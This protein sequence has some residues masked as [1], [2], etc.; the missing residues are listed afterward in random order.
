MAYQIKVKSRL[1]AL[2]RGQLETLLFF[3]ARQHRKREEI[4][5]T[6]ARYGLPELVDDR[7][8]LRVQVAGNPDV[9]TLYAVHE[10][11]GR[12]R[13]V[14]VIV[15]LRDGQ[16]LITVLHVGVA[17][18]YGAGGRYASE[19]V[20]QQLMQHIRQVARRT[21]GISHVAVAYRASRLRTATA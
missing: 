21:A 4:A 16:D 5:A 13:P 2:M 3:N 17:D 7:G 10:E 15:Y 14:G 1:P 18:D 12:A 11:D 20:L 19:R 8:W 9:Q 6:I